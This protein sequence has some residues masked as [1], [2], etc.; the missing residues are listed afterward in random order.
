MPSVYLETT[1]P[2][3]LAAS[4]SRDLIVAAHQQITHQW[5]HTAPVAFELFVSEY[6]LTEIA[7]GDP[8]TARVRMSY[9]DGLT[10]LRFTDE[11]LDLADLYERRLGLAGKGRADVP[12]FAFAVAYNYNMDYLVTWN[13]SHIAN[14]YVVRRLHV[15]NQELGRSTPIIVTPEELLLPDSG[16]SQ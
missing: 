16:S 1:I 11:V 7:A 5:W 9:V 10:V 3:Y 12:H 8:A 2:S 6:T 4:P 14:G 13:C 15:I